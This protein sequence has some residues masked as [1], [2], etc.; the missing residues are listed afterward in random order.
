[1]KRAMVSNFWHAIS[2]SGSQLHHH[3]LRRV[4]CFCL[5]M[6]S[7]Q[8]AL[9]QTQ[10]LVL[11]NISSSFL[12]SPTSNACVVLLLFF[13]DKSFTSN[14]RHPYPIGGMQLPLKLKRYWNCRACII[15]HIVL[16]LLFFAI[17]CCTAGL[18]KR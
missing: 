15:Y 3:V 2:S 11:S 14:H 12:L 16:F 17:I 5:M 4:S 8:Y 18:S 7:S 13:I 6:V 10:R 1:M 9:I